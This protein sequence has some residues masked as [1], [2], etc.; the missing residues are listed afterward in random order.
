MSPEQVVQKQLEAYNLK[1]I[2]G[3]MAVIDKDVSFHDFSTNQTTLSGSEECRAYYTNLFNASPNLHSLILK[4]TVFDNTI[5]DHERITGRNGNIDI[6]ELV[7]IYEVANEKIIRV[8]VLNKS[9]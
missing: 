6:T 8:T 3:F 9:S 5:I 1:D 7:L 4:R 2:E